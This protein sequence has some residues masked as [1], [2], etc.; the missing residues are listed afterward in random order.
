[1][2]NKKILYLFLALLL[3]GLIFVF[4]KR[5]GK[6]EFAL[7]IY[8]QDGVDVTDCNMTYTVPYL[9]PDSLWIYPKKEATLFIVSENSES[10]IELKKLIGDFDENE[11]AV[12]V[13]PTELTDV[14]E[15]I[16]LAGKEWDV[17]LVDDRNQIRGYY[18]PN[19]REEVDRLKMELSIL[20]KKY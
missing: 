2:V 4:L 5:F 9:L 20:L 7:P 15:C 1:V 6:N 14:R 8:Y 17:V 3:P 10:R 18:K 16:L 13:V 11:Y 19:T 12:A